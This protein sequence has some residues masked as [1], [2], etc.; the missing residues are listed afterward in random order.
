VDGSHDGD[1]NE[2]DV[3]A[4]DNCEVNFPH[5]ERM[6]SGSASSESTFALHRDCRKIL[7]FVIIGVIKPSGS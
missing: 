2:V 3:A 4:T 1:E 5:D 6:G 7:D